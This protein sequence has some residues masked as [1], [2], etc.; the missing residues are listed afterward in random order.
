MRMWDV[1]RN[2]DP[3]KMRRDMHQEQHNNKKNQPLNIR[4]IYLHVELKN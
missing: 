4:A 1:S 2:Y 3:Y